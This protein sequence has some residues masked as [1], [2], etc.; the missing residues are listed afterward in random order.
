MLA[1]IG[2][3][4]WWN[5]YLHSGDRQAIVAAYPHMKDYLSIW[6]MDGNGLVVHRAG[7]WDWEDWGDNIDA[8]LLDN[9]WYYMALDSAAHMADVLGNTADASAYRATMATLK[10]AF[11]KQFWNGTRLA[12][13]GHSGAPDDRGHGLAVVAGLLGAAEWPAV[14]AVLAA[15]TAASPY[16]EKYILESYFRMGDPQGGLTR[17]RARYGP[18]I[19]EHDEHA[20]GAVGSE[21]GNSK[22]R[23]DRWSADVDVRVHSR[24]GADLGGVRHIPGA[25]AAR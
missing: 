2:M 18:M 6:K 3:S 23:M 9:A 5:Y 4:G 20:L 16:M 24:S 14:K 11:V 1:T 10:P 25:A 8:P 7:E 15:N 12:G 17:M 13:P 21:R 22:S 19:Q